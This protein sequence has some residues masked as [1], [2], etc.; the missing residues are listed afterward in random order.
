MAQRDVLLL[1]HVEEK[2][3]LPHRRMKKVPLGKK[4]RNDDEEQAL[5]VGAQLEPPFGQKDLQA[6]EV[7]VRRLLAEVVYETVGEKA[8]GAEQSAD[9]LTPLVIDMTEDLRT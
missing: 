5:P 8:A 7:F 3:G 2:D 1:S 9:P 6:L 4:T